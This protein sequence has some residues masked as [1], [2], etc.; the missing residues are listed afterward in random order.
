MDNLYI[1]HYYFKDTD[2]WKNIMNLPEE[3][4]FKKAAELA[5]EH[6]DTTSFGR[7]AD[8]VNYYPQRVKAD[9]YVREEFIKLGGKPQLDHPY[10][11]VLL[12]CEYLKEW[13]SDGKSFRI[14][15]NN[16]PEDV[17]SFTI[18]D[19]CAQITNGMIPAVMT[20]KML[21]DDISRFDS[22][23]EYLKAVLGKFA[24]IEVQLWTSMDDS[25]NNWRDRK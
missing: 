13:F 21:F 23:E 7:F 2:P 11:F 4:A 20:K 16:I 17:I 8:F 10:S 1:T 9:A 19:S 15:L 5:D 14:D 3:D 24:Y 6:P 22:P 25:T 18:G 12:E